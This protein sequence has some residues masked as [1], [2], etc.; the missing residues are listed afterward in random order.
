MRAYFCRDILSNTLANI[1]G[2]PL[3]TVMNLTDV[4][5]LTSDAD[6]GEDKMEKGAKREKMT[7]RELADKY[8]EHFRKYLKMLNIDEYQILCRATDHIPEQIAM[9]QQLAEK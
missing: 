4:G 6:E 7:V 9:I 3:R 5:H 2:Y 1:M 8:I